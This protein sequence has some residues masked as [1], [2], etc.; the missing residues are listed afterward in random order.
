M[1]KTFNQQSLA[2]ELLKRHARI[3]IVHKETGIPKPLLRNTYRELHGRSSRPGA[4]KYST[5]GLTRT[6][7]KYKEVTLFAV[8]FEKV[9]SK[10]RENDI[11]KVISA[12]DIY[13]KSYPSSQLDFSAA[14][15]VARDQQLGIT[16]IVKCLHCGAAVLLNAR[17]DYSERCGVCKTK[18]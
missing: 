16:H 17:E 6:S 7:R 18:V 13:K 12:F 10:S 9:A 1:L 8:C 14:W 2:L 4:L 3:S 11:R 15:V 5:Q